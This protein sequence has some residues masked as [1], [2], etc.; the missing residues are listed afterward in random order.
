[1]RAILSL[2]ARPLQERIEQPAGEA[3]S[4]RYILHPELENVDLTAFGH[5]QRLR[6]MNGD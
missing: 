6:A 5:I 2:R 1:R 4:V 3:L